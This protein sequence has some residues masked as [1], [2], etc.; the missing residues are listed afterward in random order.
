MKANYPFITSPLSHHFALN[1]TFT[2]P[3]RN[4]PYHRQLTRSIL[5]SPLL[6]GQKRLEL[7]GLA[8][9]FDTVRFLAHNTTLACADLVA[10]SVA[11]S[12][13]PFTKSYG[14]CRF[15]SFLLRSEEKVALTTLPMPLSFTENVRSFFAGLLTVALIFI[16]LLSPRYRY[17]NRANDILTL[18]LSFV[19]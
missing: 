1:P 12:G 2:S 5:P 10:N 17:L 13:L 15:P 4:A 19:N 14:F 6:A 8:T 7:S 18:L 3:S 9:L 11:A 16:G